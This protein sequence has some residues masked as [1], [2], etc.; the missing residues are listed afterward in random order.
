MQV[1]ASVTGFTGGSIMKTIKISV[2]MAVYKGE[3]HIREQLD[4]IAKQTLLPDELV[5]TDDSPDGLTEEAIN[6]F[7]AISPVRIEYCH[8]ET[9]LGFPENFFKAISLCTGELIAFADQDDVWMPRKLE[10]MTAQFADPEVMLVTHRVTIVDSQLKVKEDLDDS[11][12]SYVGIFEPLQT[13]PWYLLF[14]MSAMAR[15]E[16][17]RVTDLKIR[18]Q[19]FTRDGLTSHDMWA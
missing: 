3:A 7:K 5:I 9:R 12:W 6:A 19:D 1:S 4:S 14:G 18:P 8:N 15:G 2:A 13:N 11:H 17:F 10:L 16:L